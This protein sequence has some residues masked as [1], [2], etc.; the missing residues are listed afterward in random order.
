[1]TSDPWLDT[2]PR[3]PDAYHAD[4]LAG[5]HVVVVGVP[6][7]E[8]WV[9]SV[10]QDVLLPPEVWMVVADPGAALHPDGVHSEDRT[11]TAGL[12]LGFYCENQGGGGGF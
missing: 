7:L 1:M 8:F 5:S 6:P 3:V 10:L 2:T 11:E 12:S 4:G 9:F